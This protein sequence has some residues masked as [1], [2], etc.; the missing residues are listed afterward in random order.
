MIK[1]ELVSASYNHGVMAVFVSKLSNE[2]GEIICSD[3]QTEPIC[4]FNWMLSEL[5]A[6]NT[7]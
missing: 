4:S 5:P 7:I 6:L 2:E 3:I 1:A